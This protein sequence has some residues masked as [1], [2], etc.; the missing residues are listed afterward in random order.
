ML[1]NV[2]NEYFELMFNNTS[3][4]E[5]LNIDVFQQLFHMKTPITIKIYKNKEQA[6]IYA[7]EIE[8]AFKKSERKD[9]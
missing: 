7:K 3:K 8:I 2:L 1:P 4:I 5:D 6:K 9:I